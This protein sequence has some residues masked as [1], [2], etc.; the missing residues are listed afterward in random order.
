MKCLYSDAY[1]GLL[2]NVPKFPILKA[3]N[4]PLIYNKVI[5]IFLKT[6]QKNIPNY[7]VTSHIYVHYYHKTTVTLHCHF[8]VTS[9][10]C[11]I[12]AL[13]NSSLYTEHIIKHIN[14]FYFNKLL[15]V[16]SSHYDYP[17]YSTL[18]YNSLHFY[19]STLTSL[20]LLPFYTHAL[21]SVHTLHIITIYLNN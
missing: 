11:H 5:K 18:F 2:N 12:T 3:T 4:I 9:L 13:A 10:H 19:N 20:L 17:H 1:T 16:T 6:C 8:T 21:A 7:S 14:Y 15:N